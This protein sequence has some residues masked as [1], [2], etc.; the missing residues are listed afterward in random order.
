MSR[1]YKSSR[2]KLSL[3][4]CTYTTPFA[5]AM[6]TSCRGVGAGPDVTDVC[7]LQ[8]LLD[9]SN[10][11]TSLNLWPL[12]FPPNSTAVFLSTD[13]KEAL[14]RASG[15]RPSGESRTQRSSSR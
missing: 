13:T 12:P 7:Q 9:M 2:T 3:P 11:H 4:A 8:S 5:L 15:R 1:E 14:S 6:A 10:T